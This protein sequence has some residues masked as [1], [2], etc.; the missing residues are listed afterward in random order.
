M[1]SIFTILFTVAP[2]VFGTE[3]FS[4]SSFSFRNLVPPVID[5]PVFDAAGNRLA[6]TNYLAMLYGGPAINSLEPAWAE[7]GTD[8]APVPFTYAPTDQAGYFSQNGAT[9]IGNVPCAGVAWLQVRA[10]DAQLG[11]TYEDVV[12]LG[13][14]GYGESNLFQEQGGKPPGFCLGS[15]SPSELLH[16]LQSF[17]LREVIPEPGSMLLMLLALPALLFCRRHRRS[18]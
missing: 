5:A 17:A 10:W 11:P 4:Q 2:F 16:G 7:T 6:G 18:K 3:V 9:I 14:G 15:P 1:K 13:L 8:M 12:N